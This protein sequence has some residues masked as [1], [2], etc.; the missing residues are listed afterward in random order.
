MRFALVATVLSS[1]IAAQTPQTPNVDDG[2]QWIDAKP[3]LTAD[4]PAIL[5]AA[6]AAAFNDAAT[7]EPLLQDVIRSQPKSENASQ[8]HLLLSRIYL[9]TGQYARLSTN[10]AAWA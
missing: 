5:R 8:A 3:N 1:V 7:A 4:S 2:R 10:F 9:R 6:V